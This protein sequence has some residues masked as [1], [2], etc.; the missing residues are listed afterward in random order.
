MFVKNNLL[1]KILGCI[2]LLTSCA[3]P[4]E[5]KDPL[6]EALQDSDPNIKKVTDR[7]AQYNVQILFTRIN[8]DKSN[9]PFFT[10]FKFQVND[11]SYFYPASTVKFPVAILALE[12]LNK[13]DTYHGNTHF[14]V[15]GDSIETSFFK[16]VS[17][18]F[19]VSD[20]DA[21][22]R[23]FEFLGPDYI[24]EQLQSKGLFPARL[25][26]RL[27]TD[28]AGN[29]TT[30][31]LVVFLND[32]TMKQTEATVNKNPERLQMK[33]IMKGKGFYEDDSLIPQPFDFS[34]KNYLPITTLHSLMKRVIFPEKYSPD[35]TFKL[36][37]EN[38][39]FLLKAMHTLPKEAGY[40]PAIYYDSY[41]KFFMYG[42]RKEAIPS[43][44]K[45]Y[46]KVGYAYGTLTDCAYIEDT[47]NNIEF[48]LTATI[49]VNKNEIFNDDV[50]EYDTVGIPFLA[51]LGRKLYQ[52][53]LERK[54]K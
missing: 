54:Q 42:D 38:E 52:I 37:K 14:Y 46:N 16:E 34:E 12:K 33:G 31:P 36:G 27:S 28:D 13:E 7:I 51:T 30:K 9:S 43:Y 26:H 23:L 44:I 49:L 48:L 17:K 41:G 45:I 10:D 22:N 15:E 29:I 40:N 8:R 4:I 1:L 6:L 11:S 53:E 39:N 47:K 19:A 20:N 32:S 3:Q 18:I 2:L 5:K 21:Y 35:E 24:N 25:S 50:Y